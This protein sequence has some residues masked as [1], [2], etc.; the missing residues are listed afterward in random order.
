MMTAQRALETLTSIFWACVAEEGF[1]AACVRDGFLDSSKWPDVSLTHDLIK[2]ER[3]VR[4]K[5]I[6]FA[7]LE[8]SGKFPADYSPQF[9]PQDLAT[10][11]IMHEEAR[12]SLLVNDLCRKLQSNGANV[13]E[14][15]ER[16]LREKSASVGV[17][18]KSF[19]EL[20]GDFIS[21][22]EKVIKSGKSLV[23][24]HGWPLLSEMIGGFNPGRVTIITAGTGVGKTN[25]SINLSRSACIEGELK[26]CFVNME[27]SEFDIA[28]RYASAVG[29]MTK[30]EFNDP[31]YLQKFSERNALAKVIEKAD[32]IHITLGKGLTLREIESWVSDKNRSS[33]VDLVFVDYDQKIQ[34]SGKEDE[35]KM[36]QRACESLEEM[37]KREDVHVILLSQADGEKDGKPKASKRM[38]QSA[39]TVLFFDE[40]DPGVFTV[41]AIKNRHGKKSAEIK[42]SYQPEKSL[43]HEDGHYVSVV[44]MM[45]GL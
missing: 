42:V 12:E 11:R 10:V 4:E 19:G 24:I 2:F 25:L 13:F 27:M 16:F 5:N 30:S 9:L 7:Q 22:N 31:S 43:I 28:T 3:L 29:S 21:E 34:V 26:A 45:R 6:N 18:S 8:F 41:R 32:S 33:K 39:S 23:K 1:Y 40:R 38:M 20:M 36:L 37:A 14:V 15:A 17:K 35:W 44:S